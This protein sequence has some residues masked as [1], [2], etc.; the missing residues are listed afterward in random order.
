MYQ[1]FNNLIMKQCGNTEQRIL[2]R[3]SSCRKE[4]PKWPSTM[5][6]QQMNTSYCGVPQGRDYRVNFPPW[7][8]WLMLDSSNRSKFWNLCMY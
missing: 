6:R 8:W 7:W 4:G 5:V 3:C 1:A 2:K